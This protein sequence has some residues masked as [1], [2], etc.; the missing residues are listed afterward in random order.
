M[1]E[2]IGTASHRARVG[3]RAGHH[4]RAPLTARP[5]REQDAA[6]DRWLES[7]AAEAMRELTADP[8]GPVPPDVLAAL[9]PVA[10]KND[11]RKGRGAVAP[12]PRCGRS[13]FRKVTGRDWHVANLPDCVR[14]VDP[15][16]HAYKN[17]AEV[18]AAGG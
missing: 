14:F 17:A 2:H 5:Y 11:R 4:D 3:P 15:S 8:D 16:R 10:K 6:Y 7:L 12:C 9:G 13:D 18:M 1:A